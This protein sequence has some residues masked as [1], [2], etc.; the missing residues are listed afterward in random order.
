M[1]DVLDAHALRAP[2]EHGVRVGRVDDV[3]D[4]DAEIVRRGDVLV[5]GVDEHGQV[6]EQRLL[7]RAG[8]AGMELD[9][10]SAD[11]DAR[12]ARRPG[13]AGPKP[14]EP[15]SAAVSS[16]FAEKSAT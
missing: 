15:Y 11:L 4:L 3:V 14:S 16:G 1:L 8:L 7:G 2:E 12:R 13:R 9:P 10:C 6:V 5:R